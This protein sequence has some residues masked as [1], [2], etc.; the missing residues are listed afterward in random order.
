MKDH[1]RKLIA[2]EFR[3]CV[4]GTIHRVTNRD[5]DYRPF[6]EAF[7]VSCFRLKTSLKTCFSANP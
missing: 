5:D 2:Q 4:D 6:H 1:Y 7:F 3:D